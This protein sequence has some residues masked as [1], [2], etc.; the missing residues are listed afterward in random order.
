MEGSKNMKKCLA[1]NQ[2]SPERFFEGPNMDL[3]MGVGIPLS[4]PETSGGKMKKKQGVAQGGI[5]GHFWGG[6][7]G[8]NKYHLGGA[9][10]GGDKIMQKTVLGQQSFRK[11]S[12]FS[13]SSRLCNIRSSKVWNCVSFYSKMRK[14]FRLWH[15]RLLLERFVL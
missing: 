8:E 7:K 9:F 15:I 14:S 6:R 3:S 2:F 5:L 12:K 1:Q 10:W 11:Y 4:A 13:K